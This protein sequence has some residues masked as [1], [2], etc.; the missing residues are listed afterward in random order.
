MV[1]PIANTQNNNKYPIPYK[2][3]YTY[4]FHVDNNNNLPIVVIQQ[5]N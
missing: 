5:L 4:L 1:Y 2:A 3:E